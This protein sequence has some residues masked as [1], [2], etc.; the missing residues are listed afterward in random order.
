MGG[1]GLMSRGYRVTAALVIAKD[2]T[3][4]L[5]N[6]YYG[7]WIPWLNDEQR[8]HFLRLGLVEEIEEVQSAAAV[9]QH[10]APAATDVTA[11]PD[12]VG[13]CIDALD[14]SGVPSDAGAPTA[15]KLCAM[16]AVGSETMS[17]LRLFASARCEPRDCPGYRPMT[18]GP[19]MGNRPWRKRSSRDTSR[20]GIASA[21]AICPS[22][23]SVFAKSR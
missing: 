9:E 4:R 13:E 20:H 10:P 7:D 19:A 17:S 16:R 11:N 5:H 1:G 15:Q 3:G 12:R 23:P 6:I 8:G 18:P 21:Q 14:R 2:Q 22:K